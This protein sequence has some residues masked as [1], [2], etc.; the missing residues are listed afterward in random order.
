[1]PR[2]P[3][4]QFPG[5]LQHVYSR[6]NRREP[7]FRRNTDYRK[8]EQFLFETI[9]RT[10]V[11]VYSWGLMPNHVH[12][13]PLTPEGDLS[14]FMR[15]LLGRFA[16]YFNWAHR[17]T[18]HVFERRFN[19]IICDQ[20]S[21]FKELIR[22]LHLQAE[23]AKHKLIEKPGT[24]LWS[25]HRFYAGVEVPPAV[26]APAIQAG[27]G[28]FGNHVEMARRTYAQFLADG[29]KDGNWEDFYAPKGDFL[30]TDD[31]IERV[32]QINQRPVRQA[33]RRLQPFVSVPDLGAFVADH[34]AVNQDALRS[35]RWNATLKAA[36]RA[37]IFLARRIYRFKGTDVASYL[38]TRPSSVSQ[39]LRR[40]PRDAESIKAWTSIIQ[41]P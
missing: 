22:Y 7:I 31:F 10:G 32:K 26:V 33:E 34:H 11:Q 9:D 25:S 2:G 15:S 4:L 13:L 40:L 8:F 3:R 41:L 37:F 5:A 12:L 23:R 17:L 36:K 29:L 20:D 30:G 21:Y 14:G 39:T 27:L 18:G 38:G 28:L 24:W 19:S 1:V 16:R 35:S 6:G